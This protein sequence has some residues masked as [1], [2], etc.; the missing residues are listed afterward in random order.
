MKNSFLIIVFIFAL[1]LVAGA[2]NMSAGGGYYLI[3]T[4]PEQMGGALIGFFQY[5]FQSWLGARGDLGYYSGGSYYKIDQGA[6]E[7]I[8]ETNVTSLP[9]FGAHVLALL[10]LG[11]GGGL[12]FGPGVS[13][14]SNSGEIKVTESVGGISTT[15]SQDFSGSNLGFSIVVGARA[16]VYPGLF[17]YGDM[18][19]WNSYRAS[20]DLEDTNVTVSQNANSI[21]FGV[22]VGTN[23]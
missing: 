17:A 4:T 16:S 10:P 7:D 9:Y 19:L 20:Y 22:G 12:Y 15:T 1:V 14:S 11:E 23:F 6:S 8:T 21:A 18:L 3:T 5:D 13:Y 2:E